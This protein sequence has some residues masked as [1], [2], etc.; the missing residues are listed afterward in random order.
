M[1][2]TV[3]EFNEG[4]AAAGQRLEEAHGQHFIVRVLAVTDREGNAKLEIGVSPEP[5]GREKWTYGFVLGGSD[6]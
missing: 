5:N 3:S 2:L 1:I 6:G 4:L